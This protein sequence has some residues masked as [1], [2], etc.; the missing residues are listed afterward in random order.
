M[1][2]ELSITLHTKSWRFN[3]PLLLGHCYGGARSCGLK[4]LASTH[5]QR[6]QC[7][8]DTHLDSEEQNFDALEFLGIQRE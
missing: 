3:I 8:W 5:Y 6:P 1:I 2:L 4:G 7:N